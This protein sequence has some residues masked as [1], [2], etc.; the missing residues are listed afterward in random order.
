MKR[1]QREF[2][3]PVNAAPDN[4]KQLALQKEEENWRFRSFVKGY[5]SMSDRRLD[6]LVIEIADQ[7]W[8]TIDCTACAQC[9][10]TLRATFSGREQQRAAKRLGI[11][12]KAFRETYLET[13]EDED[14]TVWQIRQAPCPFLQDN[15]CSIYE[16][17]PANCSGYPYLHKSR[18]RSRMWG[19]LERTFTCP[20]V[21]D[22][23]EILKQRLRFR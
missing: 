22:V 9:C 2:R 3:E 19:M 15:R 17:R 18:F 11:T 12:A 13:K 20:A 16:V 5:C 14:G 1:R 23:F 6:S 7:V 21:F 10:K 8:K 4:V